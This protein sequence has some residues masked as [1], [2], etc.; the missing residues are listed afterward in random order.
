MTVMTNA[1]HARCKIELMDTPCGGD[2]GL[3]Q[4]LLLLVLVLVL[5]FSDVFCDFLFISSFEQMIW[6]ILLRDGSENVRA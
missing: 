5:L 6:I 2:L 1:T 3:Y 4:P